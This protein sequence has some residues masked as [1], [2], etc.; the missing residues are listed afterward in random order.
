MLHVI[1]PIFD[2]D[3]EE[4][5]HGF[6]KERSVQTALAQVVR[7]ANQ[8]YSWIVDLDI[9]SCFERINTALLF[10]FIKG[11][12]KDNEL[13]RMVRAWLDIETVAVER[14]G[15]LRKQEP[16]GI[17]QGGILSPLFANIYLDRFDK[18]ALKRGLKLVRYGDDIVICCR[19]QEEAEATLKLAQKLLAKLDLEINPRK[20][21]IHHVEKGLRYLGEQLFLKKSGNREEIVVMPHPQQAKEHVA[22]LPAR[23]A[24]PEPTP[25]KYT[26]R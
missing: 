16:R 8:G 2:A 4:C 21:V 11:K 20:T 14:N 3:F 22:L 18:M 17:L 6:R 7:L 26:D 24:L 10:K 23:R 15:F 13:R 1:E 5:S 12:L 19:S 25:W 9:A